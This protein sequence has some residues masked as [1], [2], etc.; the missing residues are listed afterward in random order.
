VQSGTLITG[1]RGRLNISQNS[2]KIWD[3]MNACSNSNFMWRISSPIAQCWDDVSLIVQVSR[4]R[5]LHRLR[6][7]YETNSSFKQGLPV[8]VED[9]CNK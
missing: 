1:H 3:G 5:D 7:L 9:S 4:Y 2:F 6:Y 8:P